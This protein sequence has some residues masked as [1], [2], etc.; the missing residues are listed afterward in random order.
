MVVLVEQKKI[1]I[2]FSNANKKFCF[3]L[4]YNDDESY[5]YGNKTKIYKFEAKGNISWYNFCLGSL[6]KDFTKD[7]QGEMVM[8]MIFQLTIVQLKSS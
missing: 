6:P 2:N 1:S 8:C 4:H 5:L 3:S 7:E